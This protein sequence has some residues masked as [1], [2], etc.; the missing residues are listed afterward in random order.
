LLSLGEFETALNNVAAW[1]NDALANLEQPE[2]IY[3]DPKTI[4][5]EIAKLKVR[6]HQ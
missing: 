6:N 3:A 2:P 1:L 4:E 5:A